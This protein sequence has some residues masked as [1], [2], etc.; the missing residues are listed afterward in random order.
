MDGQT[1]AD[2]APAFVLPSEPAFTLLDTAV[3]HYSANIA[4]D[5]LGRR[6]TYAELGRLTERAAAGLQRLGVAKGV[7]VG[8]CL[9]NCPYFVIMY[10]AILKAGGTV[11]NFNPLYTDNEIAAQASETETS[12]IVSL[13]VVAIHA[14]IARLAAQGRFSRVIVCSM[15]AALPLVKGQL[16]R[17]LKRQE[18]AS[19]P[20]AAPYMTFETL[21]AG[22]DRLVPV[23]LDP[24]HDIA[25]LQSTGGTTGVPK[26][27]MLTHTN[28][29]ANVRQVLASM[30]GL[31]QGQE[32]FL[33]VLPF[34]HVFA[35]TAVMNFGLAIGAELVLLP[36]LDMK[37]MMQTLRRR[38]PTLLPGV[39]TLFT[40]LCNAAETTPKSDLSCIKFGISGGAPIASETIDR[41]ERLAQRPILEGYGLSETS[42]VVSFNLA[43][44]IRRGSVGQAVPGTVIEIRNP[45]R[46]EEILPQG[47]H[48]EICV[49]GPQV[50]RGYYKRPAE[51]A[52][53]FVEGALRTGD[54]GYLDAD[55]YLFIVDRIKDL[56]LC[57]GYNVYPRVIE[58]AA[59]QHPAVQD[60]VAIGVPD[61]YRG[62]S[63]KLFVTLRAGASATAAEIL[64][65]LNQHL[66]KIE[67][68]RT[69]EIRDSLPKTLVGKLSKKELVAEEM[70]R[71][72]EA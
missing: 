4:L 72:T 69:V 40:A 36:R 54:I 18:L 11:V 19:V 49:R 53:V 63:P 25:V 34:F 48:G 24:A 62:Q 65:F 44:A 50:M 33:A 35:M 70:K 41:F 46:P 64:I 10:Y 32:R 60:A 52:Q 20:Q 57:G 31:Q 2:P 28:V 51:T 15:T 7:K 8:L 17:L 14:K 45:D 26:A 27:A 38:R 37:L 61:E 66:N 55:G 23:H 12:L 3:R 1:A 67:C 13:D 47:T 68:P 43:G 39:P 6:T 56:I 30:A 16:F 42:P 9:P 29:T 22:T 21:I 59:Y 71:A 5:F 58:E